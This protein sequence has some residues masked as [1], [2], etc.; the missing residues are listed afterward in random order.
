MVSVIIVN[1]NTK[2]LLFRCL[3]VVYSSVA[4]ELLT[5][6]MVV[7]NG[8]TDGSG[9]LIRQRFPQVTLIALPENMGFAVANNRGLKV[10][11]GKYC[12]L[13]NSDVQL[14]PGA[15]KLMID[16][17]ED[18]PR[19][20]LITPSLL[21][22]NGARQNTC[23]A[24]PSLRTELCGYH[25]RL[26]ASALKPQPVPSVRGAC[27][28]VRREALSLVAGFDERYF[29][30]LEET[31]LCWRLRQAGWQVYWLPQAKVYHQGGASA[32]GKS[33]AARIEYWRSRYSFFR[34]HYPF[35]YGALLKTGLMIKLAVDL[36]VNFIAALVTMFC[37]R[38]F[39]GKL[40]QYATLSWWHLRGCPGTWGLGSANFIRQ[41]N[42][43]VRKEY[44]RWWEDNRQAILSGARDLQLLKEN[45]QR[46]LCEYQGNFYI[47]FYQGKNPARKEWQ[48]INRL[49]QLAVPT[50]EAV[51]LGP[52]C[53]ITKK[54][55]GVRSLHEYIIA[56]QGR[57]TLADKINLS[58][59]VADLIGRLHEIGFYHGD[60]HAGNILVAETEKGFY[61]YV[62]DFHRA[63]L[64]LRLSNR[65]MI[66]NLVQFN[67]FFSVWVKP[68]CRLRF[69]CRYLERSSRI[70][71][72]RSLAVEI[73]KK[74]KRAC[75]R[76]WQKRDRLYF[77]K[78][79]YALRGR[80]R[81]QRYCLNPVYR[82][83]DLAG[84]FA[85]AGQE[86]K[87]SPSSYVDRRT[88]PGVG[89]V[90]FKLSRQKNIARYL[91][92]ACRYSRAFRSWRASWA[93]RTREIMTPQPVVALEERKG[94]L[95]KESIFVSEYI[96]GSE[97]LTLWVR[98]NWPR[99]SLEQKIDFLS[100]VARYLSLL[101]ERGVFP[102]DL[103]AS[104]ILVQ[105]DNGR[106]KLYLID[107]DHLSCYNNVSLRRRLYNFRQLQRSF[108]DTQ[109]VSST[110]RRR[111]LRSYFPR[112]SK[113]R[114]KGIAK[115][116][117][118]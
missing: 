23:T 55:M 18:C 35:W 105:G 108:P 114:L 11:R 96:P 75:H 41:R 118:G 84:L 28:L 12:L 29:L 91:K 113:E 54:L 9:D 93:L 106:G 94:P 7:D 71:E 37:V 16:F 17:M 86:I 49:G 64:K 111:F 47:K 42:W 44:V 36:L 69:L 62:T 25:L 20:G 59:G 63:V 10:A 66:N 116:V 76:L 38:S 89:D 90:V 81:R 104:N 52:N 6:V 2:D 78:K 88:V 95:L 30:F 48:L 34:C 22:P 73:E 65:Q 112:E 100:R 87:N 39:S 53:L 43:Q 5:E 117:V 51:A 56:E 103:K 24:F 70:N 97:N 85:K 110:M 13:L 107:L 83:V 74:T 21:H 77:K 45:P 109:L 15:L 58:R 61:F 79:K 99:L 27:M 50:V 1:W 102:R 80:F 68:V 72:R 4:A 57:L 14:T 67:M 82:D 40:K 3:Q 98:H 31:D 8:S 26:A 92:D 46:R 60:L 19:A 32:A 33:A 101:H 115:L